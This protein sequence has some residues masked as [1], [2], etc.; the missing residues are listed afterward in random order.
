MGSETIK[1]LEER[2]G[3]NS[4]GIDCSSIFLGMSPEARET[5]VKVKLLELHQNHILMKQK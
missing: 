5:K 3:N 2:T 4:S 1:I